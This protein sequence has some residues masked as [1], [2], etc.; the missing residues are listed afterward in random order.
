MQGMQ[1]R[2]TFVAATAMGLA[3]P[4]AFGQSR[5]PERPITMVVPATAGS[6]PDVIARLL[7]QKLQESMGQPVVIDS[8]PGAS[9]LI[10]AQK[11][12]RAE[13]DGYTLLYG[14]NQIVTMNPHLLKNLPYDVQRDFQPVTMTADLGYVWIANNDF[15][16][17]TVPEW[18]AYAKANPRKTTFGTTGPGSAANLGGELFMQQTGTQMLAVPYKASSRADLVSGVI[19]LMMDPYTTAIPLITSGKVKALAVTGPE[20]LKALPNVPTMSEFLNGYVIRG[21]HAVWARA[22]TPQPVVERL[23]RE[24]TAAIRQPDIVERMANVGL[25]GLPMS[26]KELDDLTREE[27]R[28]WRDLIRERNIQVE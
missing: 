18:I 20:R 4:L 8:A 27:S 13:P 22:G 1:N 14:F 7:G 19:N 23:N 3:A 10:G 9:G 11:L 21:W 17:S 6:S 24:L 26:P 12:V 2:R 16:A 25:R 15:P 5:Y 28:M